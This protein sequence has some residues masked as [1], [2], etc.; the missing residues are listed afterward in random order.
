MIVTEI[1]KKE[2][3]NEKEGSNLTLDGCLRVDELCSLYYYGI[4]Y[5]SM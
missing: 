2:K 4:S 5:E 3:K 1:E